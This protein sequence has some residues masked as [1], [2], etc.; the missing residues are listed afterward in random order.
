[1]TKN[2]LAFNLYGF[3]RVEMK[4][5]NN[6]KWRVNLIN[7]NTGIDNEIA[8][9]IN[10]DEVILL[11]NY[12]VSKTNIQTPPSNNTFMKDI[13]NMLKIIRNKTWEDTT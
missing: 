13:K 6:K 12:L 3:I 11:C 5:H 7:R 4:Q 8:R 10:N 2:K 9:S 1:M